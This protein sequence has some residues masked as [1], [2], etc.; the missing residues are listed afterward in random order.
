MPGFRKFDTSFYFSDVLE[1]I[2][3]SACTKIA[4][5]KAMVVYHRFKSFSEK[6]DQMLF[7]LRCSL[8]Q[9]QVQQL[10][11]QQVHYLQQRQRHYV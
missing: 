2:R 11:P 3:G 9:L 4:N 8:Q 1:I 7:M 6:T 5:K 10:L